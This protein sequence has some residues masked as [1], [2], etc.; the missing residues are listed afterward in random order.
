VLDVGNRGSER[1]D[2]TVSNRYAS[3]TTK[4]SI[5]PGDAKTER[6]SLSHTRG[7]YDLVITV[8]SDP[9]LEYRYAGHLENGQDSIS[10][11]GM[12]ALI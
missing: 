7:W 6:W 8:R 4:L 11:P 2:V 3:R 10:D 5:K 12:G 9:H 1:L